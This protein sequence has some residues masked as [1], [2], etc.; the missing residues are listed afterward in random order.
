MSDELTEQAQRNRE[1]WDG[2]AGQWVEPGR[3]NWAQPEIVW[4]IWDIPESELHILD[5]VAGKDVLE[6]GCGTAYWSAWL[7][8][9]GARVTGLDNSPKQLETARALQKEFGIEFPLHLGSAESLPFEDASFDLVFN[10]YGAA[11]WCD[12]Y[13]WI[14]EAARVLRAGGTLV[15]LG[16]SVISMLCAPD[17]D[18]E[19]TTRLL[20]PQFGMRRFSWTTDPGIEFHISHSEMISLLRSAGFEIEGL[21]ELQAPPDAKPHR[22]PGMPS[23]EW[24]RKWPVEEI[25]KARKRPA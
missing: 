9:R 22:F 20:R 23:P 17:D 10:E 15:F 14:P 18:S 2:M 7:A 1:Y 8:R 6:T 5:D 25:W 3:R 13:L 11:I 16:N 19:P 4:G 21:W 12:P 24:G